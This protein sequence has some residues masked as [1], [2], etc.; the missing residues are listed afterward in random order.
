MIT[1]ALI[2]ATDLVTKKQLAYFKLLCWWKK[3]S[4]AIIQSPGNYGGANGKYRKR[5][6]IK[7]TILF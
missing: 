2:T 5:T 6:E 7:S 3:S 1:S 4:E